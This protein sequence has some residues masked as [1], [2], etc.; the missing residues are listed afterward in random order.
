MKIFA[1]VLS[2]LLAPASAHSADVAS[3]DL[4]GYVDFSALAD[5]Y[6]EARVTINLSGSILG[7]VASLKHDNPA[8][9]ET[10]KNLDSVRVQVYDTAGNTSAAASR[11]DA[12]S[13]KLMNAEWEQVIR[14]REAGERVHVFMKQGDNRIKGLMIMAVDPEE[15]VFINILG[16]IDP[17]HLETVVSQMNVVGNIDLDLSL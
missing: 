11:M 5:E 15:A 7:L 2:L 14:V 17:A 1:L 6:G 4:P 8:A 10:L 13:G 3:A 16:D 12:V 9:S